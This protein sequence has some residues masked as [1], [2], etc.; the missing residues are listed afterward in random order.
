MDF[1]GS[2][3]FAERSLSNLPSHLQNDTQLTAHLASRFHAHYPT[4]RLSTQAVIALNTYTN[5]AKGPNGDVEESAMGATRELASRAWARLGHRGE[6]Q[7][8]VFL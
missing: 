5:A 2:A 1:D 4:A 3:Q 7:A 8:M 6:N